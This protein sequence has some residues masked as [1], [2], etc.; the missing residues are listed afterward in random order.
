R[1]TRPARWPAS[2]WARRSG[3]ATR[4]ATAWSTPSATCPAA[5]DCSLQPERERNEGVSRENGRQALRASLGDFQRHCLG[6]PDH[7]GDRRRDDQQRLLRAG[8]AHALAQ[9]RA[10]AGAERGRG[11]RLGLPRRREAAPHPHGRRGVDRAGREALARRRFRQ[12]HDPYGHF[13]REN[14]LGRSCIAGG[15]RVMKRLLIGFS[16]AL[17]A[18]FAGAQNFPAKT[19]TVII[20]VAPGGTLDTLARQIAQGLAPLLK[21][22]VVVENVT[23]AGGLVGFQ[24]LMKADPDCH[25]LNFSNMSLLIIPHM[26]PRGGFDP[27]ADLAP[28]SGVATVPMVVAVSNKSGIKDLPSLIAHMRRNPGKVNLGNGGPGT[29]AHLSQ[30]L[31]LNI[32]K[33]DAQLI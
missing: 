19:V 7:A 14:G 5:S 15:L 29:T 20:G 4:S 13:D 22:S 1:S 11:Q 31:F 10:R 17:A 21:Q 25:T 23:G 32:V 9:P 12:L 30:A 6:G 27:L 33:A 8:R 2:A 26:H 24:R 18:S 28:V 3:T 16:M